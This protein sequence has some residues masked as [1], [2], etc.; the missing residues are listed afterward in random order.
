M[1]PSPWVLVLLGLAAFR[2]WKLLAEDTIFDRPRARLLTGHAGLDQFVSCPWCL[3][4]WLAA[5]WWG[6]W[7]LWPHPTLVAAGLI[8]V[9]TLASLTATVLA[10]LPER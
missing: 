6:C 7:Q 4:T 5:V 9:V 2:T 3:G 10:S 8:A 1:I